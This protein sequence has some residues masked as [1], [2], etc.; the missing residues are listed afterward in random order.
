MFLSSFLMSPLRLIFGLFGT[1]LL[2]LLIIVGGTV[3]LAFT[4]GPGPC[5]P[6]GGP[7]AVSAANADA[8][9]GKWDSFNATLDGGSAATVNFNES[10]ISSFVGREVGDPF[11]DPRVC[12]HDG[13]G[14]GTA[15]LEILGFDAKI[16]VKGNMDLTG[17]HPV[18]KIDD[19]EVGNVPGF[20]TGFVENFVEDAI[21]DETK[22]V[23]LDHPVTPTLTEGDA[24][25]DGTPKP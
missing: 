19:I 11:S 4:G 1:L 25:L 14:E 6:G 22:K 15:T 13:S 16:K 8:F 18:A 23:D 21:E 10:E 2:I 5:T 3:V 12:I 7:I 9:D 20:V 24:K 17:T